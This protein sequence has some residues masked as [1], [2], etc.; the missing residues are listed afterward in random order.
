MMYLKWSHRCFNP[1]LMGITFVFLL[2][3]KPV[4]LNYRTD[5]YRCHYSNFQLIR[6]FLGSGKT[7]TM[8]GGVGREAG[9]IPRTIDFLFKSFE[10]N[11]AY[12]WNYILRLSCIE[13]YNEH[14][15]HLLDD[16]ETPKSFKLIQIAEPYVDG[17]FQPEVSTSV[18]LKN[19]LDSATN[20]RKTSPSLK[21]ASSSRSHFIVQLQ[22]TAIHPNCTTV[23]QI[24]LID[25]AGCESGSDSNN[26]T[27]TKQI[28]T[29]LLALSKILM[30]LKKKEKFVSYRDSVLTR[31][32][33][34]H[35]AGNSK[36]L[37]FVNVAIL[38]K[39]L[40]ESLNALNFATSVNRIDDRDILIVYLC[41]IMV[42]L[43]H[44]MSV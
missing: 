7:F 17:L 37:T 9:V 22:L 8:C 35:L 29:S 1:Q 21:N 42:V 31:L 18:K 24:N 40:K 25:L 28:N 36:V 34:P 5:K 4:R 16:G 23:S 15:F 20:R 41:V 38:K 2:M 30:A 44:S 33:Q 27:E 13:V 32:L 12:G 3:A 6:T 43:N 39:C 10:E 19:L 26:M 14:L 11:R